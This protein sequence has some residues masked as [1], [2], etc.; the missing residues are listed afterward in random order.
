VSSFVSRL[1]GT[2]GR[3]QIRR[4]MAKGARRLADR[5]DGRHSIPLDY[6]PTSS[7]SPR[8]GYGRPAHSG[9]TEVVGRHEDRYRAALSMVL[10]YRDQLL[11]IPRHAARPT[12]PS[13]INGFL[14]GL[15]G[16]AIYSF[17]RDRRPRR[18]VEVGSGN[19]TKFAVRARRDGELDFEIVSIDPSPRTEVEELCDTSVR[20][21][22]E[23]ADLGV[24]DALGAGDVVFFDGSHRVFM[25]SDV[26]TFFLDV[27]PGLAPGVLVGI[28]DVYLPDDYDP[29]ERDDYYSEQYLLATA[30]LADPT[31]LRPILPG[32]YVGNRPELD[33]ILDPLWEDAAMKDVPRYGVAF[34][35]ENTRQWERP[36]RDAS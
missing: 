35:F 21:P 11:A 30:L 9:L 31:L 7:N 18:Y 10:G 13:W 8:W 12:D 3:F 33:R 6:P 27:L 17:L 19:S 26:V 32:A 28:H 4:G 29:W 15:D 36:D 16:A 34:W 2:R 20:G 5:L 23:A 24:F 25:N 1:R 22:L 14:P